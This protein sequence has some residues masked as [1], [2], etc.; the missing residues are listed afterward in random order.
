MSA[1]LLLIIPLLAAL[2]IPFAPSR[3]AKWIALGG[4]LAALGW[5]IAFA[6]GFPNWTDGGQVFSAG[7]P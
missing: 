6:I 4:S 2:V 7:F 1:A 5:A 3:T